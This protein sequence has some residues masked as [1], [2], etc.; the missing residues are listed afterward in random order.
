MAADPLTTQTLIEERERNFAI[1]VRVPYTLTI[2]HLLTMQHP[3]PLSLFCA[4]RS[5]DVYAYQ[6]REKKWKENI[7][8]D[9]FRVEREKGGG[10]Y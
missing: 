5:T 4:P 8:T 1:V 3:K 10:E 6:E 2:S 9:C 7:H